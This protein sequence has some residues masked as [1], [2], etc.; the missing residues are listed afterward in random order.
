M[1]VGKW[2]VGGNPVR[3]FVIMQARYDSALDWSRAQELERRRLTQTVDKLTNCGGWDV[4][5]GGR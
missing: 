2:L 1:V 4:R 5:I 3:E